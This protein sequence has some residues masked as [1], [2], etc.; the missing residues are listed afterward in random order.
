MKVKKNASVGK[1]VCFVA[2]LGLLLAL[3]NYSHAG[4]FPVRPGSLLL[5][6][7]VNYFYANKSWDSAGIKRPFPNN[8]SYNSVTYSLYME[9]GISRR[10]TLVATAP[11]IINNF[12]QNGFKSLNEGWGD[13]ETGLKYY[14][15]NINYTY[16]F[17]LQG[18]VIT[19]MYTN[20]N[21]GFKESG[22]EF[23]LSFAGSGH[24]IGRNFFFNIDNGIRQYFGTAGPVQDRYNGTFGLSLD[25][26]GHH[27][28]LISAGG[29]YSTS[30]FTGFTPNLATNKN[31][32]FNQVGVSYGL[33]FS[34]RFSIFLNGSQFITGRNTGVGSS[35]SASLILKPF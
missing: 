20:P 7:S 21:M 1:S 22:A 6:P 35:A 33:S 12:Q 24:M 5:S 10:F 3:P 8:G 32:A 19:P 25:K 15:A 23:K 34:K 26:K 2:L 14:L 13:L 28:F 27:L 9:Y 29:F 18:T 17:S 31:F 16:Y 4:G 30:S 11:Y